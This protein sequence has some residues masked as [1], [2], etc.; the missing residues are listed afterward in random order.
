MKPHSR[1]Q[2]TCRITVWRFDENVAGDALRLPPCWPP[3]ATEM[4]RRAP[5]RMRWRADALIA[6]PI[7][8]VLGGFLDDELVAFAAFF[9]CQAISGGQSGQLTTTWRLLSPRAERLAQQLITAIA[10]PERHAPGFHL[11]WLI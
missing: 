4:R 5:G 8:E 10:T 7:A 6:D 1:D 11:R 9:V 2:R 3:M